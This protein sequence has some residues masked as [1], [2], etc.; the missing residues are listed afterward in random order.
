MSARF[1]VYLVDDDGDV[2]E[3]LGFLLRTAGYKVETFPDAMAFLRQGPPGHAGCIIM[4]VRMPGM[5]GLQLLEQL[6]RDGDPRPVVVMTGHADVN[7]CRRAFKGGAIDFLTKPVDENALIEAIEG[8]RA[9]AETQS[10]KAAEAAEARALLAR[11][12][13]REREVL[14]MVS[15]GF[16]TKEIAETLALSPRTVDTHRAHLAEK[17]GTTS[18]AEMVRLMLEDAASR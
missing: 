5:S 1:T 17:L 12:T 16:A 10:A 8:M 13:P 6:A 11:L 18:V 2:R 3:A 9:R 15:R 7:A 4:D 14:D